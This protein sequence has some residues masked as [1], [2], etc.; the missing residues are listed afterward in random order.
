MTILIKSFKDL[1]SLELYFLLKKRQDVFIVEQKGCYEDL[2]EKDFGAIHVWVQ[3]KEPH[4]ILSYLRMVPEPEKKEILIGRVL[5]I[6]SVRGQGLARK[7]MLKAIEAVHTTY[8]GWK[9]SL[10]AQDYLSDFYK[11]LGF[12]QTGPVFHYPGEEHLPHIPMA[13]RKV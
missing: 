2:D 1:T 9:I 6:P 8:P 3:G 11:S 12:V 5:T 13:Y 10:E 7:L 4:D